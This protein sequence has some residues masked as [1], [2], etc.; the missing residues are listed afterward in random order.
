MAFLY[1][2]LTMARRILKLLLIY[3]FTFNAFGQNKGSGQILPG[4]FGKLKYDSVVIYECMTKNWTEIASGNKLNKGIIV[5]SHT[6][7]KSQSDSVR[8]VLFNTKTYG[9]Y[10]PQCFDYNLGIVFYKSS[11][12]ACYASISFECNAVSPSHEIDAMRKESF[13]DKKYDLA[14]YNGLSKKG[15]EY[16]IRLCDQLSFEYP[17]QKEKH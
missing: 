11:K 10:P 9:A 4:E 14:Y 1:I 3:H 6:L 7:N 16:F 2:Y 15:K 17:K 13:H 8:L 5:K 12:I